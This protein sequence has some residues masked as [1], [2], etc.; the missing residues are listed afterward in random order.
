MAVTRTLQR[1]AAYVINRAFRLLKK[2]RPGDT[3]EA[4]EQAQALE[5]LQDLMRGWEV[6][7]TPLYKMEH[8]RIVLTGGQGMYEL[9]AANLVRDVHHVYY[10]DNS[11]GEY[12]LD[13]LPGRTYLD[14]PQKDMEGQPSSYWFDRGPT[15][16]LPSEP[17]I[18]TDP[19]AAKLYLWPKPSAVSQA[20]GATLDL[21]VSVPYAIPTLVT[22]ELDVPESWYNALCYLLAAELWEE[23]GGN[24]IR[25]KA[26]VMW[27]GLLDDYRP[28][29]IDVVK[30]YHTYGY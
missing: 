17:A 21:R 22:D 6:S 10:R 14:F 29:F 28:A 2:L 7:D 11:G 25:V 19:Q 5:T 30:E 1:D 24:D 4:E 9:N 3:L 8:M 13:L 26:A 15:S 18:D 20:N 16:Y 23:Y 12:P 27:E